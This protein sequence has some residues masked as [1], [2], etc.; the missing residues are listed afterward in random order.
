[1]EEN[2]SGTVVQHFFFV[3][4]KNKKKLRLSIATQTKQAGTGMFGELLIMVNYFKIWKIELNIFYKD[5]QKVSTGM[6]EKQFPHSILK[7]FQWIKL[8]LMFPSQNFEATLK[9]VTPGNNYITAGASALSRL[10]V[11]SLLL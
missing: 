5:Y 3:K 10:L 1:M 6:K 2:Q 4:K 7:E 8:L 11:C 9:V